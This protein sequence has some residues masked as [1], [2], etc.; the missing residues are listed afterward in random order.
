MW[1]CGAPAS[2]PAETL[3][4]GRGGDA[5][6]LDPIHTDIGESVKV[7]INVFDTLVAYDDDSL[8][9]V[10]CLAESWESDADGMTW[11]FHLRDG[12]VFHDGTPCDADAVVFSLERLVA[13]DHPHVYELARPYRP[14][15]SMIASVHAVDPLTVEM[16]LHHSSAVLLRNLAM[17]CCSVVSP[18]AVQETR[19]AFGDGPVG[20]GPFEFVRWQRDQEIVLKRF[21]GH[22][23]GPA[24]V[25]RLIFL[26]VAE[27]STRVAQLLRGEIHVTDNLPP[28]ELDA[29]ESKPDVMLQSQPGLNVAYLSLQNDKPPLDD[30]RVRRAIAHAIDKEE[31]I[32]IAYGGHARPAHSLVPPTMWGHHGQLVDYRFD[33]HQAR[34]LIEEAADER[35]ELLPW[36]LQLFVMDRPR[37]YLQL[38]LETATFLRD[39]LQP[40]GIE[41]EIV[42]SDLNL[43]FERVMAGEHQLALAGWTTDNGD[44]D[45]FL[46]SL[47]DRDNIGPAGNNLGRYRSDAVHQLLVEA[48]GNSD[49]TRRSELYRQAQEQILEDCP[50]IPLV[51]TDVRVALRKE[52]RDYQLHPSALAFLRSARL[53][54]K[55]P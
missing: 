55:T 13:E 4:Y 53:M 3:I 54:T 34:R 32:R 17:F 41:L 43:H 7:I 33:R 38:P 48:Q 27:P 47:L 28:P 36:R 6:T 12:V 20:T 31:L 25:E 50:L 23:R 39:S 42:Q 2:P 18:T 44:P 24:G 26:P 35:G 22:W 5:Q 10:P 16:R 21:D 15:F 40:I 52:V 14:N 37:P 9:I 1:G 8:D 30:V 51:H 19:Q 49:V 11:R 46:Y 29:L 45:N